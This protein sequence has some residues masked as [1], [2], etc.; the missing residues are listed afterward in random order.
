MKI[1]CLLGAVVEEFENSD[2]RENLIRI[3]IGGKNYGVKFKN[4]VI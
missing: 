2:G 4:T 3:D 1:G